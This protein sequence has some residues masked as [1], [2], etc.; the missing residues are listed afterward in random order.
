M[1]YEINV[2]LDMLDKEGT[3]VQDPPEM[4]GQRRRT[5]GNGGPRRL[6]AAEIA[7][8][9]LVQN[10]KRSSKR[11]QR[12]RMLEIANM[13]LTSSSNTPKRRFAPSFSEFGE[14]I[15]QSTQAIINPIQHHEELDVIV[16]E[17]WSASQVQAATNSGLNNAQNAPI[18]QA[19]KQISTST[20]NIELL[21]QTL[22][23]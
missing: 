19:E 4:S 2:E 10:D 3:I 13:D 17:P 16:V 15:T 11:P 22:L 23:S 7:E 14:V 5:Y 6:T 21:P 9:Q 20:L 1:L 12:H 18:L 8:K